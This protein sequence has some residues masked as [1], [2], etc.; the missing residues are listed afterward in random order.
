MKPRADSDAAHERRGLWRRDVLLRYWAVQVPGT[1]LL[2]LVLFVLHGALGLSLTT[3]WIVVGLWVLKDAALYPLLWRSFDPG[4]RAAHSMLG[5]RG[6]AVERIDPEGYVRVRGE[7]WRGELA[8]G[9]A[10]IEPGE[11][12]RVEATGDLTLIVARADS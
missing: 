10:P 9:A 3:L 4:H 8:V 1:L 11:A 2:L 7:R 12:V 5:A 6:E